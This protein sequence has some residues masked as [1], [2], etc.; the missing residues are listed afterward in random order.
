MMPCLICLSCPSVPKNMEFHGI[1]EG[2]KVDQ[3]DMFRAAPPSPLDPTTFGSTAKSQRLPLASVVGAACSSMSGK[4][5]LE[6]HR[7][8]NKTT[9]NK[10]KQHTTLKSELSIVNNKVEI[11]KS[12]WHQ[13]S[14]WPLLTLWQCPTGRA[15]P[16]GV[17]SGCK[18]TPGRAQLSAK[19]PSR[20]PRSLGIPRKT[21][22]RLRERTSLA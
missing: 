2:I 11:T 3:V 19:S 4:A 18:S 15:Q 8:G 1:P 6:G 14:Q 16:R 13:N 22:L 12:N 17:I 21:W 10:E 7:S 20:S 9:K 5:P